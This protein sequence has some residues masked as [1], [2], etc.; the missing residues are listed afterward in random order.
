M[1]TLGAPHLDEHAD[2]SHTDLSLFPCSLG[3]MMINRGYAAL[4]SVQVTFIPPVIAAP[5]SE[6]PPFTNETDH[7]PKAIGLVSHSW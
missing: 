6:V 3:E 4:H 7:C 5:Q 1:Q 2:L